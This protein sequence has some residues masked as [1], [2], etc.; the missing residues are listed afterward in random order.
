MH[1]PK[2]GLA[3]MAFPAVFPN[4]TRAE[5]I[6]WFDVFPVQLLDLGTRAKH[7]GCGFQNGSLHR[8]LA[9]KGC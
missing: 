1:F 2:V 8:H 3:E 6:A 5:T 4:N 9:H 7:F